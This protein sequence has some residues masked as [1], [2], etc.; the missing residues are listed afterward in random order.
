[1]FVIA[2]Y[3]QTVEQ[4]RSA[5]EALKENGFS[6][7]ALALVTHTTTSPEGEV[8]DTSSADVAAAAIKAGRLLG[9]HSEFYASHMQEGRSLVVVQPPF[10]GSRLA[11]SI[12]EDHG[13]LDIAHESPYVDAP[14]EPIGQRAT[15]LSDY[16]NWRVLS[17][18]P[19]PFSEYWG[20]RMISQRRSF[21]SRMFAELTSPD[22]ALFGSVTLSKSA[23]PLSGMLSLPTKSGESGDSWT[24]SFGYPLLSKGAAPLS[25]S[26]GM[27][28]LSRKRSLY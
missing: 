19:A 11:T 12:L 9:E 20:F 22:Y 15:P 26:I 10:G 24:S 6:S 3:Y 1:M 17:D 2:R 16:L 8:T 13:P 4:A 5:Y 23:A 7:R 27:P 21:L 28:L 25:D 14:F 18:E